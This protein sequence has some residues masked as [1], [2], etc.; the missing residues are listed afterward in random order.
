MYIYFN[1]YIDIYTN[2]ASFMPHMLHGVNI[3]YDLLGKITYR[4]IAKYK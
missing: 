4:E 1:T 2:K 3:Q